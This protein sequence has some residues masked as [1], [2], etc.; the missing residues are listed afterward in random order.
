MTH[1]VGSSGRLL[2][3]G[4]SAGMGERLDLVLD[5]LAEAAPNLRVELASLTTAVRLE[6]VARR[7][8][9]A[10]FLRGVEDPPAGIRLIPVWHD[11]LLVVL[12]AR[13]P[14]A[15]RAGHGL[16]DLAELTGLP[17]Y[18]TARRNN[19][20]LVDLVVDACQDAGFEPVPGPP[21]S[22]LQDTPATEPPDTTP[23]QQVH[24]QS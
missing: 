10:A 16:T 9:D 18:L 21:H 7:E 14:V 19:P 12:P 17:L 2:R 24:D 6:R 8:L 5:T 11:P 13:H 23:E 22:S 3:I 4:T 15:E 1:T 20:P